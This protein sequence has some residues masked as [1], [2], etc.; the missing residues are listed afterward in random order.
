LTAVAAAATAAVAA[1][2]LLLCALLQWQF[3]ATCWHIPAGV[4]AHVTNT[5]TQQ[6]VAAIPR[7]AAAV[8]A[9]TNAAAC[10]LA[11]SCALHCEYLAFYCF[12]VELLNCTR[13][14]GWACKHDKSISLQPPKHTVSTSAASSGCDSDVTH[15][16]AHPKAGAK[17][18][19]NMNGS[20]RYK[21]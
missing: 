7:E 15:P 18:S 5:V 1:A 4:T 12:A 19:W 11:I 6:A 10:C 2:V 8:A 14:H 20:I 3:L 17:G 21:T 16:K 9:A 13:H